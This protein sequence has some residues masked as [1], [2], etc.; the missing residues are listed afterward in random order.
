MNISSR[1]VIMEHKAKRAGLHYDVRFRMPRSKMWMS[2]ASRKEIPT[3]EGTRV[4][5]T[6]TTDHTEEEALFTGTIESG[7]GA[8]V[9]K[10]WDDGSCIILKYEP[11]RHIV[12]DFK[13]RKVKGLYHFLSVFK[14]TKGESY[15]L[16]KGKE[17]K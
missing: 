3:K 8:G 4:M 14:D 7:Y 17:G 11:K 15:L 1:F 10:K 2:F 6:R 9:L 5:V 13:G 16:F 12:V